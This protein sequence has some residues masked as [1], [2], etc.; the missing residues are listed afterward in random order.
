M[1]WWIWLLISIYSIWILV[2]IPFI[3]INETE[4][5]NRGERFLSGFMWPIWVYLYIIVLDYQREL[6]Y[7]K[8][9]HSLM[10]EDRN[11]Q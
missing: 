11:N 5:L 6:E 10:E 9:Q 3:F 1:T 7:H 8:Y 2:A 4:G